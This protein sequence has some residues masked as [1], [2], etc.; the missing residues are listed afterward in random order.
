M[1]EKRRVD[2]AEVIVRDAENRVLVVRGRHG[3]WGFPGGARE[4]GESFAEAA[5]RE[6]RE[7]TGLEIEVAG[8][9]GVL[10]KARLLFLFFEARVVAGTAALQDD[11]DVVEVR[12]VD[13]EEAVRLL[14]VYPN[15]KHVLAGPPAIY[16]AARE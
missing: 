8:L 5:V 12:W 3:L 2:V 10:E 4:E 1:S 16:F 9:A 14:T 6:T 11:E 7:E 13:D 15:A